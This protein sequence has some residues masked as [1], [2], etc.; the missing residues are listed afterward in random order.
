VICPM[1]EA[2]PEIDAENVTDSAAGK[3][4]LFCFL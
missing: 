2:N 1:V 3:V 4:K